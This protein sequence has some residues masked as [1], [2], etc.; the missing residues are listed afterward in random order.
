MSIWRSKKKVLPF[1][2]EIAFRGWLTLKREIP[3]FL[4]NA[5]KLVALKGQDG[6][7]LCLDLEL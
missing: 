1:V 4:Q 7:K 6:G 2:V 5:S 3:L